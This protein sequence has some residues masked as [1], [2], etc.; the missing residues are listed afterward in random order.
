MEIKDIVAGIVVEYYSGYESM[1]E[2]LKHTQ[3]VVTYTRMIAVGEGYSPERV[4]LLEAAAWL[5][6]IG[7]PESKV[8]YGNLLPVNQQSVGCKVAKELLAG[9]DEIDED[10]K[11]WLAMVVATH[12]QF[13]SSKELG[14]TALFEADLIVNLLSGYHA[15]AKADHLYSKLMVTSSGKALFKTL[16]K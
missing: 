16:I 9:V 11:E 2:D 12:H 8:I 1:H 13:D 10:D 6:D 15:R 14:F 4:S 5:H 3:E 7:C